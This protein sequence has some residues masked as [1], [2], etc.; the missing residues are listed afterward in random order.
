MSDNYSIIQPIIHTVSA[1]QITNTVVV[2]SPGPQGPIGEFQPLNI[3]T[4]YPITNA[5]GT[6]GLSA[7]YIPAS[8]TYSSSANYSLISA[9]STYSASSNVSASSIYATNAGS[10][11]YS[12]NSGN[13]S[14]T[15]QTN[16]NTLTLSGSTVATQAYVLSNIPAS[17]QYA[18]SAIYSTNS[19]SANYATV[20]ASSTNASSA[21]YSLNSTSATI[22]SSAITSTSAVFAGSANYAISA[23]SATTSTSATY[24]AWL[25]GYPASSYAL[26]SSPS[27]TGTPLAPTAASNVSNTQIATTAYVNNA[28]TQQAS[29]SASTGYLGYFYQTD[30]VTLTQ[31]TASAVPWNGNGVQNGFSYNGSSVTFVYPGY[32]T[33]NYN[34]QVNGGGNGHAVNS[35]YRKNGVDIPNTNYEITLSN[36]APAQLIQGV[37]TGYFSA[38]DILQVMVLLT[39]GTGTYLWGQASAVGPPAQPATPAAVLNIELVTYVQSASTVT[40]AYDSASLGG[41]I[42]SSYALNSYVNTQNNNYY[43][44]AQAYANTA[45]LNA[46]NA[47]SAY[48]KSGSW[49]NANASVGYATSVGGTL[50]GNTFNTSNTSVTLFAT[51]ASINIGNYGAGGGGQNI[52]IGQQFLTNSRSIN[53]G[54]TGAGGAIETINIGTGSFNSFVKNINIGTGAVGVGTNS[55]S[56]VIGAGNA[57]TLLSINAN[58]NINGT[59]TVTNSIIGISSSATTSLNSASLG[60]IVA[61]EY[62]TETDVYTTQLTPTTSIDIFPRTSIAGTRTLAAGTIYATGFVPIKNFTLNTVTIVLTSAGT[63]SIQFGLI[64]TSGSTLTVVASTVAVV[65][66]GAGIFTGS[67]STPQTLTA[68]QSYAIGFLAVGGTNPTLVGQ[69]FSTT[70]AGIS[71]G[72][73]PFMAANSSTTTYTSIPTAGNTIALNTATPTV[74]MAWARLS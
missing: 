4:A 38:G 29:L 32:Y 42:S 48:T 67:F 21:Q 46:Y 59:L 26:L 8:A 6:I 28:V 57:T 51:P 35:W 12:T 10:A 25:D 45:S 60:G 72:L 2:S 22:S 65:P 71:Y 49:N 66:G 43:S 5:S 15:S 56:I 30:N 52:S 63:S 9:S 54:A 13:S 50:I 41:I 27:F 34:I 3:S 61:S 73:S 23:G 19:G 7:S 37:Y 47:A 33:I 68:G 16:F 36:Q 17:A 24:S 64:S 40:Y 1:T 58:A 53:I 20:S 39:G 31:N 55:S 18:G 69:S 11:N 62:A 44:S 70:N 14:T 74:G